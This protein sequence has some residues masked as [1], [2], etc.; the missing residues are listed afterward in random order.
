MI[1]ARKLR[2]H[3]KSYMHGAFLLGQRLGWDVL[4]R[5]FYSS[6]P[7]IPKLQRAQFWRT[8]SSMIGVNGA[9]LSSQM[10]FLRECC[11]PGLQQRLKQSDIHHQA[12][13]ENGEPGGFGPV[14]ANFLF[15]YIATQRPPKIVQVGCGVSTAVILQAARET[16]YS[17]KIVCVDPFPSNYLLHLQNE[18]FIELVTRPAEEVDLEILTDIGAGDLFFVDSTHAIRPGCE[19]NRIVLE[20]LQRLPAGARVHF[21]DIWWPYDYQPSLMTNLFFHGESTLLHAYMIGNSRY[22]IAVSLSMLHHGCPREMQ[23]VLPNYQPAATNHGLW[24]VKGQ[25]HLPTSTYLSVLP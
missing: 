4:P 19:V 22:A 1:A 25:G 23:S 9:D 16:G 12:G 24:R 15:C 8:A 20:I 13:Q 11:T 5:H 2:E 14:E 3:A 18:R 6:I 7:D 17:P 10:A 21:H